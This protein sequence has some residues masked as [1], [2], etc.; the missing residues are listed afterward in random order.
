MDAAYALALAH[1]LAVFALVATLAAETA[2]L[3]A[4]PPSPPILARLGRLDLAYGA[5]AL[6]V[7]A[8]GVVRVLFSLKGWAFYVA[9]PYFWAKMG[10]FVLVGALS[11]PPTI[12]IARWGRAL[13]AS[14][15]LPSADAVARVRG[16]VKAEWAV[17]AT[18]P[19]FAAALGLNW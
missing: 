7:I 17:L 18:V 4:G 13:K 15:A 8:I 16:W 14:G 9:N 19:A 2:L 3:A 5:L 11:A 12:A 6:A 10:A 1:H